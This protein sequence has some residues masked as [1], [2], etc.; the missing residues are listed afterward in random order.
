MRTFDILIVGAGTA[1]SAA[2][3]HF[4]RRGLRT[5]LLDAR[6]FSEAGARW[7]NYLPGWMFDAA[8]LPRPEA[9]ELH[10]PQAPMTVLVGGVRTTVP[11]NPC[12]AVDMRALGQRLHGLGLSAGVTPFERVH[13]LRVGCTAGRP[14]ELETDAGLL[15]AALFIDASGL[16]GVL[17]RQVPRLAT[18]CPTVDRAHLCSAAQE[19]RSVRDPVAAAA[20]QAHHRLAPDEILSQP[21]V[22]GGY[23][24][25]NLS[26]GAGL[27]Q[28][29]LLTG[30]MVGEGYSGLALIDRAVREHPW[31]GPRIFGGSGVI[32]LR[33]PY[34]R[35]SAPGIALLGNAACQ[36][37][38]AHGS[39]VGMGLVAA[40][41]LAEAM[42]TGDDPGD[43][44][45]LWAWQAEFHHRYGATLA[46][47]D[48][49]RRLTQSLGAADFARLLAA[50]VVNARQMEFA[51]RQ[52]LPEIGPVEASGFLRVLGAYP[53]LAA[54]AARSLAGV[55][56]LIALYR[57]HPARPSPRA[58]RLWSR[59]VATL[60]GERPD[61]A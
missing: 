51:L 24:V 11:E 7:V 4:A 8:A 31:I 48:L 30:C 27:R 20:W 37:F 45:R 14:V 9:P 44:T 10:S 46:A 40:R 53:K 26:V 16:N 3:W 38:P 29:E 2:A 47:Y 41:M 21:G 22:A 33:R 57:N 59:A 1:G 15:R 49:F 58:L 19:V 25:S 6:P 50:G 60:C 28:V 42:A 54:H 43:E 61:V 17:R 12:L 13:V 5:A 32:P 18:D 55:P 35:L 36:V 56:G 52:V 23:S 34:D 39:G